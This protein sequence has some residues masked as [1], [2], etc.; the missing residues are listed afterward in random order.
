MTVLL[1]VREIR[2]LYIILRIL[3]ME[4]AAQ[5]RTEQE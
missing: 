1:A 5:S 3:S 4:A 2:H